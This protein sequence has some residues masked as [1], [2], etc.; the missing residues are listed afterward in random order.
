MNEE[1]EVDFSLYETKYECKHSRP[2]SC[3]KIGTKSKIVLLMFSQKKR[4][5]RMFLLATSKT[6]LKNVDYCKVFTVFLTISLL[7]VSFESLALLNFTKLPLSND[8]DTLILFA[9]F[10]TL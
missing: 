4:R 1:F 8:S 7:K 3:K 9:K 5:K 6:L 10:S 2:W